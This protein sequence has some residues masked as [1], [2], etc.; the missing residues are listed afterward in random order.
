MVIACSAYTDGCRY[1]KPSIRTPSRTFSV[2]PLHAASVVL[3][4]KHSPGPWPYM[5]WKWSK[6]QTPS[7]PNASANCTRDAFS[8]QDIRCWATSSP[9]R[10][11]GYFSPVST[12]SERIA[13]DRSAERRVR[14][15]TALAVDDQVDALVVERDEP[16]DPF[17]FRKRRRVRPC[18]V[19]LDPVADA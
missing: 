9:N 17:A 15:A 13:A 5:G 7:K 2:M 3:A 4:S 14:P 12:M 16:G 8:F 6:P 11:V 10:I 18:D 1:V 19:G